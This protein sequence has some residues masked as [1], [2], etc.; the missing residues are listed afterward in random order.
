MKRKPKPW[1]NPTIPNAIAT[2]NVPMV[3][4]YTPSRAI[5]PRT[6]APTVF[7]AVCMRMSRTVTTRIVVWLVGSSEV[8]NH[9]LTRA[10]TYGTTPVSTLATVTSR[11]MP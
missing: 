2:P 10:A 11:A 1:W 7:S 9:W 5:R 4:T 6:L 8:P 3:S